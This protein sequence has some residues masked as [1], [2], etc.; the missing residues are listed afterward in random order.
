MSYKIVLYKNGKKDRVFFKSDKLNGIKNKYIH[1]IKNNE[2]II[3]KKLINNLKLKSV[4]YELI[5]MESKDVSKGDN[6][7]RDH[8]GKIIRDREIESG[9]LVLERFNYK[10]EENFKIFGKDKRMTCVEIVKQLLLPNKVPKQVYCVLNKLII[11]D[12]NDKMEIITCKNE[13]ESGRLHDAL[14]D[15]CKKF[16]VQSILFFGR[17]TP[18]NR[19]R[20]YPKIL[21]V[22]GWK[23]YRVY[24]KSTRP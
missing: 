15:I 21:K 1:M 2:V 9:W 11:E 6:V 13:S 24:R 7:V 8:M 22:T 18:E 12:D 5:L 20:I 4:N 17:A 19:S 10:V 23:K 16:E 3:P 14:R